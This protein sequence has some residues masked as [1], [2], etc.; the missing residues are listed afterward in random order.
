MIVSLADFNWT[1]YAVIY[2][3]H[4]KRKASCIVVPKVS[5]TFYFAIIKKQQSLSDTTSDCNS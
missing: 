2:Q 5:V 1:A 4:E 3:I